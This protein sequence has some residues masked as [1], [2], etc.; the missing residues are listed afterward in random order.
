[1]QIPYKKTCVLFG[2][3]MLSTFQPSI[4]LPNSAEAAQQAPTKDYSAEVRQTSLILLDSFSLQASKDAFVN[5]S[6]FTN[7]VNAI[8]KEGDKALTEEAYT[9]TKKSVLP[10]SNN[11]NDYFSVGP[12]WWPDPKKKDG[13][14]WI[15][16]DGDVNQSVRG[17]N[18]DN[19]QIGGL[20]SAIDRLALAY[21]FSGDAK[22]ATRAERLLNVFFID[23]GTKMNPHANYA[24]SI[25]GK[26]V[27][28][29]IGI[30]EFREL[31]RVLDGMTLMQG[32]FSDRT[33]VLMDEWLTIF[34]SWLIESSN[35]RDENHA[36]NNHG[37]FY[38]VILASL[39]SYLGMNDVTLLVIENT[40]V[41]I[42]QQI[43]SD[44]QQPLE[45]ARTR[46]FHYSTFNL[47]AFTSMATIAKANGIDL[48]N[49]P[50][51]ADARILQAYAFLVADFDNKSL[52]NG[53]QEK[54]LRL[55][56]LVGLSLALKK[57]NNESEQASQTNAIVVATLADILQRDNEEV[58]RQAQACAPVFNYSQWQDINYSSIV[59]PCV[60]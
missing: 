46:P 58:S 7:E 39:S 49:Y 27:G 11:I 12:Y 47:L 23:E 33:K 37:T 56:N 42:T 14:P 21:Y 52:W 8:I 15:R 18:A 35:G 28:R 40:K 57:L 34:M 54:E 4:A 3:L 50:S 25:P 38:D 55:Q 19:R 16:R 59:K 9:V 53:K 13:L 41:R 2:L 10:A 51:T 24:Q 45:L 22:Y 43:Q 60:Y 48:L 32:E 36:K 6:A 20:I 30:I 17:D 44:G 29:G 1:M 31:V 5:K 26:V